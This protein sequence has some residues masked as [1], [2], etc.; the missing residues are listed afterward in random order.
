MTKYFQPDIKGFSIRVL[1]NIVDQ[2]YPQKKILENSKTK[3]NTKST[4][5]KTKKNVPEKTLREITK[6][7]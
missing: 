5:R 7:V 1:R 3:T 2:L 6:M 4:N